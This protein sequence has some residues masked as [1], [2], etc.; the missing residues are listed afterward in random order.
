MKDYVKKDAL[1]FNYEFDYDSYTYYS[2]LQNSVRI[3]LTKIRK[4]VADEMFSHK[5]NIEGYYYELGS[6]I[7]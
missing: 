5:F 6:I 2:K 1:K 7:A 4:C 3:N